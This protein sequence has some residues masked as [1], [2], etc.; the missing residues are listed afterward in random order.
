MKI[1]EPVASYKN[2]KY[3]DGDVTQWLINSFSTIT[4]QT[5]RL[6]IFNLMPSTF[7]NRN[8]MV[9]CKSYYGFNQSTNLTCILIKMLQFFPLLRG[10]TATTI[11]S[12]F[13]FSIKG[14]QA[15]FFGILPVGN[16]LI[17]GIISSP[18]L[19]LRNFILSYIDFTTRWT[20]FSCS[21]RRDIS[22]P[23]INTFLW[24]IYNIARYAYPTIGITLVTTK[25]LGTAFVFSRTIST[26]LIINSGHITQ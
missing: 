20:S 26:R 14:V 22:I 13:M 8:D 7:C 17:I 18:I 24:K 2:L 3:P 19:H 11:G 25:F 12:F 1:H 16:L 4:N 6:Y 9:L 21:V 15:I 10:Y 5:K 23:T